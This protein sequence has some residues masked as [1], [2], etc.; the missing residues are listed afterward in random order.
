MTRRR[1]TGVLTV[2]L[3]LLY[4]VAGIAETTRAVVT[5]D[6]GIPFWFGSLVG[7]G[8]LVLLGA[9]AF[10]QRPRLSRRLIVIGALLGVIATMWTLVVPLLALAVVVLTLQRTGGEIDAPETVDG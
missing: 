6:G 3:G 4:V 1:L 2:F 7:G 5:G 8:T 10:R 9:L